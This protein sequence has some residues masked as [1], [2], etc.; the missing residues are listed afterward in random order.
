[1]RIER[2]LEMID[3][4]DVLKYIIETNNVNVKQ[5]A[6]Q[7]GSSRQSIYRI[8]ETGTGN[9]TNINKLLDAMG[10]ELEVVPKRKV[11]QSETWTKECRRCHKTFVSESRNTQFC[12]E[13]N[14]RAKKAKSGNK[15]PGTTAPNFDVYQYE[16]SIRQNAIE[17]VKRNDHIVAEGYA[18][19][20]IKKSLSKVEPI[21]T[22]L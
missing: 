3:I 21:N 5:L 2:E 15:R 20:Q 7:S 13:C 1:M 22:K 4:G 14:D 16:M 10:Y 8:I 12:P 17:R 18:D 19:R 6:K 11:T 9:I